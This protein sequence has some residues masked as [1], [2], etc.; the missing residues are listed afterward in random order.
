[1]TPETIKLIRKILA[2]KMGE[3]HKDG[4]KSTI[5]RYMKAMKEFNESLVSQGIFDI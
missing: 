5:N 2:G 3:A 4:D 1:M